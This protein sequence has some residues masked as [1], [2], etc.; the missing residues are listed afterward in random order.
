MSNNNASFIW[1]IADS[2]RGIYTASKNGEVIL[3]F[4]VLR[5]IDC[6]IE[7]A[8]NREEVM[9][10]VEA[11]HS[12]FRLESKYG[13]LFNKSR[14][15][16]DNLLDDP[17]NIKANLIDYIENF[18]DEAKD[19]LDSFEII[20]HIEKLDKN[21]ILFDI[22]RQ[23]TR[24]VDLDPATVSNTDMGL[25]FEELIRKFTD[26]AASEDGEF[27]TPRDAIQLL[28]KILFA[29]DREELSVPG[30]VRTVYDPTAGT[31]GMLTVAEEM[32]KEINPQ[33]D[34]NVF[35][36]EMNENSYAICKSDLLIKGQDPKNVQL[37]NTLS[38]DRF[39][40]TFHYAM[41]NPPYGVDWKNSKDAVSAEAELGMSGRFGYGL[42]SVSD[43]Q[44]LFLC[45]LV[46]K[47]KDPD[48]GGSR[49]GI[50]MNGSSLFSGAAG[51][52]ASNIR[53][54]LFERDLVEAIIGLPTNMF[55]NT[56]IAT[57]IWILDN[58]KRDERIGKVQLID[59]SEIFEKTRKSLGDKT[60]E[61]TTENIQTIEELYTSF[62]E[63]DRSKI[64]SNREF[65]YQ[66]IPTFKPRRRRFRNDA[67]AAEAV[68]ESKPVQKLTDEKREELRE[69]LSDIPQDVLTANT[70][71]AVKE[72]LLVAGKPLPAPALK[73]VIDQM[74][75]DDPEAEVFL[76]S[77][78]DPEQGDKDSERVPL[79]E[80]IEEYFARE[81]YPHAPDT[82]IGTGV[83]I[84]Y[85][86]PFT[87]LFYKETNSRNVAEIDLDINN[88][89]ANITG[90]LSTLTES[91]AGDGK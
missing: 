84:G 80:D 41:S 15:S 34:L 23:F 1:S 22:C 64:L 4:T 13:Y 70:H 62:E 57:Y 12:Q 21:G 65:G 25:M 81:V 33:A 36:Q 29:D 10:D 58:T 46:S 6:I 87:R 69:L 49:V 24:E 72:G 54:Y 42:P 32:I 14:H 31:G 35:G 3:P 16:M 43:G 66:D 39:D 53:K 68:M 76:G 18:S 85:E 5:R 40:R 79:T 73:V 86:V 74:S 83:K 26:A 27:F 59:A 20:T 50:V 47:M 51:S 60:R 90:M 77:K 38:D 19:I 8:D 9:S 45:H 82:Q 75:V 61:F 88:T 28:A 89:I 17:A 52:G 71:K 37:G 7:A 44:L 2:L 67:S 63:D 55:Y 91:E 11:G 48:E 30:V 56:G 78:G